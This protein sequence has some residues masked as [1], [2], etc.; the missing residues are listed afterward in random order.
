MS[1]TPQYV[2]SL[3]EEKQNLQNKNSLLACQVSY[4]CGLLSSLNKIYDIKGDIAN[5]SKFWKDLSYD[6]C[7]SLVNGDIT[8]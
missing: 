8:D 7:V 4:L 6:A 1:F 3:I 2:S 5:N